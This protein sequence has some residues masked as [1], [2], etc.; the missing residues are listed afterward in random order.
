MANLSQYYDEKKWL[1][2]YNLITSKELEKNLFFFNY[3]VKLDIFPDD[4][5][6]V[7][8]SL[9]D[10]M[11]FGKIE[12]FEKWIKSKHKELDN[13]TPIEAFKTIEG[14]KI[15]REYLIRYPII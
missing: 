2:F 10:Y 12:V 1:D 8:A 15:L 4:I 13:N 5:N 14:E 6:R 7:L 11:F 9:Y 3:L